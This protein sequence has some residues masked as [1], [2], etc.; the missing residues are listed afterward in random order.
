MKLESSTENKTTIVSYVTNKIRKEILNGHLQKG[1]HLIQEEWALKL[2]VSRMPVREAFAKLQ[3]ERLVE[4]IPHKGTI[5]TPITKDDIEEIYQTRA[6]MEG[7]A[8]EKAL[9]FLSEKDLMSLKNILT[10]M[11]E[12][13]ISDETNDEYIELNHSFHKVILEACPW[14]RLKKMVQSLGISPIAPSLLKDYYP[15]TQREHRNIYKATLRGD[16]SELKAAVEYHILSTK[17]NLIQ[18]MDNL[19]D[20]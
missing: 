6:L 20:F 2:N 17:N 3:E 7:F 5:V 15:E 9:P 16:P 19:N 11:E 1:E 13:E 12:L 18:H 8:V 4:I 10:R 14:P